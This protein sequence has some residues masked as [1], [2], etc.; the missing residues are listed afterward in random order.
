M[1][2]RHTHTQKNGKLNWRIEIRGRNMGG[3]GRKKRGKVGKEEEEE[4]EEGI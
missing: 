3:R 1:Q 4:E 2:F